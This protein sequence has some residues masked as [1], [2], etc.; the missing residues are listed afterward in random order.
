[1]SKHEQTRANTSKH[2]QTRAN[3]PGHSQRTSTYINF[4]Q[5]I[6]P[7]FHT[8]QGISTYNTYIRQ[9]PNCIST[10]F[11][12][13]INIFYCFFQQLS[14]SN[15]QQFSMVFPWSFP[16]FFQDDRV[17]PRICGALPACPRTC[18]ELGAAGGPHWLRFVDGGQ[19]HL[20]CRQRVMGEHLGEYIV[21]YIYTYLY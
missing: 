14:T 17:H 4:R 20:P 7:Y 5:R 6:S 19:L 2:E 1:M 18:G 15:D 16:W 3:R 11:L 13:T 10:F 9:Y 12:S 21:Q 8:Y